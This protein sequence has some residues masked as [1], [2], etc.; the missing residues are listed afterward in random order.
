[1]DS[2]S[3]CLRE[4][5]DTV[6]SSIKVNDSQKIMTRRIYLRDYENIVIFSTD[7]EFFQ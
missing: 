2:C 6:F 3:R 4:K 7:I 1:M 5:R